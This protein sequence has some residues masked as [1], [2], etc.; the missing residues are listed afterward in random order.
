M[1]L[2]AFGAIMAAGCSKGVSMPNSSITTLE[3][4]TQA[5]MRGPEPK[6]GYPS[7]PNIDQSKLPGA[8]K[9]N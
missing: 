5:L 8:P 9:Q 2:V 7:L 6:G 3:P 4:P 1:F